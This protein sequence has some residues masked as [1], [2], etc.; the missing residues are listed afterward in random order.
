MIIFPSHGNRLLSQQA[1]Q[2]IRLDGLL[3]VGP[4]VNESLYCRAAFTY[5]FTGG[6]FVNAGTSDEGTGARGFLGRL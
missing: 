2:P 5:A 1:E 6:K 3:N 4:C